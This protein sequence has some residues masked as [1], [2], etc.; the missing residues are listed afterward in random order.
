MWENGAP[1]QTPTSV[2]IS[3]NITSLQSPLHTITLK[4]APVLVIV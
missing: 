4:H 1:N 3:H 2:V